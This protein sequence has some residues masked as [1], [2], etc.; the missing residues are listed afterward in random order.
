LGKIERDCK[1]K[2]RDF[3]LTQARIQN[4]L[5]FI[6]YNTNTGNKKYGH[7]EDPTSAKESQQQKGD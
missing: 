6:I 4:L 3:L 2:K 7:H 5:C 1:Q